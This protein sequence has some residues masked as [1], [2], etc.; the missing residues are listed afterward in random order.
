MEMLTE[1][2]RFE[3]GGLSRECAASIAVASMQRLFNLEVNN[4]IETPH[5]T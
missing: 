1:S 3:N 4:E 5:T 2:E